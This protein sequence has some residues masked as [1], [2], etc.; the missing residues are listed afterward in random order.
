MLKVKIKVMHILT[1]NISKM[2]TD[3]ANITITINYE[4]AH[5]L[6]ISIL[7]LIFAYS[8]VQLAVGMVSPNMLAFL[9]YK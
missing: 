5:G 9:F 6:S 1:A 8:N 7:D 3:R 2:V 4:F